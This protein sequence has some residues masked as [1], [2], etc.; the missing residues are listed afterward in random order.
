MN[1]N[2]FDTELQKSDY[3]RISKIL[4]ASNLDIEELKTIDLYEVFP[5]LKGNL[6]SVAGIWNGFDE[7]WLNAACTKVYLKRS[8]GFFRRKTR[9][10]NRFLYWMRKDHWV[11]IENRMEFSTNIE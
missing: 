2:K 8:N 3:D 6:L 1:A 9:L 7:E 10:Y 5:V 4:I 11:E